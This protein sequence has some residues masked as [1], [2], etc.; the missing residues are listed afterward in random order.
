MPKDHEIISSIQ[1]LSLR[2]VRRIIDATSVDRGPATWGPSVPRSRSDSLRFYAFFLPFFF[3]I[4]LLSS[5]LQKKS[6]VDSPN[7]HIALKHCEQRRRTAFFPKDLTSR[8]TYHNNV[9]RNSH[10]TAMSS[11]SRPTD[12]PLGIAEEH[13]DRRN[14]PPTSSTEAG[15]G[16]VW[17]SSTE[18]PLHRDE[19]HVPSH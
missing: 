16:T 19:Q 14:G 1:E 10:R 4:Y 6:A 15:R 17:H 11:T 13:R 3:S 2:K 12:P 18:L 5:T 8:T 9:R 7:S